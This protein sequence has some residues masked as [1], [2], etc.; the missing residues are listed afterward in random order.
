MVTTNSETEHLVLNFAVRL[1]AVVLDPQLTEIEC[2]HLVSRVVGMVMAS[3]S[4]PSL[5]ASMNAPF[6][7]L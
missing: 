3:G 5:K 7:G 2:E 4:P 1:V 6:Q